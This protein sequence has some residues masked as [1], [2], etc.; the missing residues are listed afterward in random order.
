MEY[1]NE[2]RKVVEVGGRFED[3][4]LSFLALSLTRDWVGDDLGRGWYQG[5]LRGIVIVSSGRPKVGIG[6]SDTR[7]LS[8]YA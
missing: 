2:V 5:P 1:R 6:T 8:F 4:G 7:F 3:C